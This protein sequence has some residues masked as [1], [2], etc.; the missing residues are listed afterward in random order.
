MKTRAPQLVWHC[1]ESDLHLKLLPNSV[2]INYVY[3]CLLQYAL[4]QWYIAR[5]V[6]VVLHLEV[7][8]E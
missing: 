2:Y 1:Q 5:V 6:A 8:I 4:Y 3:Q 7:P